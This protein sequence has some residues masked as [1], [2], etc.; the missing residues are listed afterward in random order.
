M[1]IRQGHLLSGQGFDDSQKEILKQRLREAEYEIETIQK[2]IRDNEAKKSAVFE[3]YEAT[4]RKLTDIQTAKRQALKRKREL[5]LRLR[6]ETKK[7]EVELPRPCPA[8][9]FPAKSSRLVNGCSSPP[10][11][12]LSVLNSIPLFSSPPLFPT[13]SLQS[14]PPTPWR[15]GQTSA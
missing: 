6:T 4:L 7:L 15:R 12:D 13:C 2:E 9:R 8:S 1:G 10:P 14:V 3:K 11:V 5:Q